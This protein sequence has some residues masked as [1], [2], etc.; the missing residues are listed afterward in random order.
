LNIKYGQKKKTAS[1]TNSFYSGENSHFRKD[2]NCS[3]FE[4]ILV[5]RK[6][7]ANRSS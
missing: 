2:T 5:K 6:R 4:M 7:A 3:T 1:E